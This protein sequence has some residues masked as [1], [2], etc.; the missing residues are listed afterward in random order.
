MCPPLP[1][2]AMGNLFTW[3]FGFSEDEISYQIVAKDVRNWL[4]QID[5]EQ[6]KIIQSGNVFYNDFGQAMEF[7]SAPSWGF[8]IS[9]VGVTFPYTKWTM[10]GV[11]LFQLVL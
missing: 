10:A 7:L 1:D 11:I 8:A 3:T 2:T 9:A 6:V 4:R 5:R